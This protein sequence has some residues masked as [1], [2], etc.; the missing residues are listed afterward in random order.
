MAERN[1]PWS[2]S[3]PLL[4]R[5][6]RSRSAS[7][8]STAR[9]AATAAAAID[10]Q[11]SRSTIGQTVIE[12]S[13]MGRQE[14]RPR[15]PRMAF[16]QLG[17]HALSGI[18]LRL[19]REFREQPSRLTPEFCKDAAIFGKFRMCARLRTHPCGG[20]ACIEACCAQRCDRFSGFQLLCHAHATVVTLTAWSARPT[21]MALRPGVNRHGR[22]S[23]TQCKVFASLPGRDP[24]PNGG[25]CVAH[26]K[27]DADGLVPGGSMAAPCRYPV[28]P[29]GSSSPRR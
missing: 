22:A 6:G 24:P 17:R 3:T 25:R 10:P 26:R 14:A 9:T 8:S 5:N 16:D 29:A 1:R 28:S 15:F 2:I 23:G 13:N 27:R 19:V 21:V 11:E 12:A 20:Y 7:S 4:S 18:S